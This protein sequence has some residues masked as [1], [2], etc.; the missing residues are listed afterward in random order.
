M[1]MRDEGAGNDAVEIA[2]DVLPGYAGWEG[3][4]V[5]IK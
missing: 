4:A 3:A 1:T 2:T 5:A